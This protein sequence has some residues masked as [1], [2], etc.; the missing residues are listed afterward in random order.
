MKAAKRLGLNRYVD[1]NGNDQKWITI[2]EIVVD[3]EEDKRQ[4][5]LASEYIHGLRNID[6]EY[7]GA[8]LLAHLYTRPELIVV[9]KK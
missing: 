2:H 8:N 9:K 1:K 6:T 3:T 4:L 5:L 7:I